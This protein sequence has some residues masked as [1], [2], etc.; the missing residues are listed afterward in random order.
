[1]PLFPHHELVVLTWIVVSSHNNAIIYLQIVKTV[2]SI[3][4]NVAAPFAS[5]LRHL[6]S[7]KALAIHV[8]PDLSKRAHYV[9]KAHSVVSSVL[10]VLP[11]GLG[12]RSGQN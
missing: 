4:V 6:L 9:F 5:L 2:S 1:M 11:K 10:N 12:G 3:P 8:V 7:V